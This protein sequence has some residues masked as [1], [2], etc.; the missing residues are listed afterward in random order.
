MFTES[1][2][3]IAPVWYV[4]SVINVFWKLKKNFVETS[5]IFRKVFKN[6]PENI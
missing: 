5:K 4:A 2:S 3:C 1:K 6:A